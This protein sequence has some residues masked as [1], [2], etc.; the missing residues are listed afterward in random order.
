MDQRYADLQGGGTE[1]VGK[2]CVSPVHLGRRH[3]IG[4]NC[5][6]W[7][8]RVLQAPYLPAQSHWR[9]T[10]QPPTPYAPLTCTT[11]R[12]EL[13][14]SSSRRSD[15]ASHKVYEYIIAGLHQPKSTSSP[16]GAVMQIC[17]AQADVPSN[18]KFVACKAFFILA[19]CLATSLTLGVTV[20][21][22]AVGSMMV[23][24]KWPTQGSAKRSLLRETSSRPRNPKIPNKDLIAPFVWD[25]LGSMDLDGALEKT[26]RF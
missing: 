13:P 4:Q 20:G 7:A 15:E 5:G 8:G 26:A 19:I 14:R 9:F 21:G 25:R 11:P 16:P 17:K 2:S 24:G 3:R 10:D 6:S 18:F 23:S 1:G 12:P 22:Q